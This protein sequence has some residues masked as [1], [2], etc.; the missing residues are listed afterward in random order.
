MESCSNIS[1]RHLQQLHA[2]RWRRGHTIRVIVTAT[3]AGGSTQPPRPRP[4]RAGPAARAGE[5]RAA[6]D[7]R[8]S[9]AGR[10][11]HHHQRDLVRQPDLLQL[12]VA[13][14]QLVGATARNISGATSSATC[15]SR[16]R[17][18]H[19]PRGRHRHQRRRIDHGRPRPRPQP[20]RPP[21]PAP[22]NTAP[23][24]ISGTA[25]Q[26][27]T[28]TTTNGT[29]SSSPTGYSYQ[30]QDCNS[31]GGSCSNISGRHVEQLHGRRRR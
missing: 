15:C 21:P 3:N 12:P 17:R 24:A 6:G 9:A 27:D 22:V 29:W 31:S 26:G 2:R 5:H 16:R 10:H 4:Q 8:D 30:W 13:G 18:P 7:Q 19:D 1:E 20:C 11:A 25:Q 28:L 23:P 14:L